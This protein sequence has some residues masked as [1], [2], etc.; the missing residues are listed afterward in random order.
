MSVRS[1]KTERIAGTN[2]ISPAGLLGEQ[3]NSF[4]R[5]PSLGS[6]IEILEKIFAYFSPFYIYFIS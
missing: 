1:L 4:A 3:D 6:S 2:G 5:T